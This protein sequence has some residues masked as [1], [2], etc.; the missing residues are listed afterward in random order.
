MESPAYQKMYGAFESSFSYTLAITTVNRIVDGD[1]PDLLI[2][3]ATAA[4][5]TVLVSLVDRELGRALA[6]VSVSASGGQRHV[7]DLVEGPLQLL[8]HLTNTA[9]SVLVQFV[10]SALG[11]WV[12]ELDGAQRLDTGIPTVLVGT[13]LLWLLGMSLGLAGYRPLAPAVRS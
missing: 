9:T 8:L 11:R 13:A 5:L 1:G 10:S 6:D 2:I 7:L 12:L 4:L 3:A